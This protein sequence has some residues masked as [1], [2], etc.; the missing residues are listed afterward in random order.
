MLT[1]RHN[2]GVT[3]LHAVY[4]AAR[5]ALLGKDRPRAGEL[6]HERTPSADVLSV[7]SGFQ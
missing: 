7:A 5:I 1:Q 3:W 2:G 4:D 6:S